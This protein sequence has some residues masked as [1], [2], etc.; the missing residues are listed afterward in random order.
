MTG[1]TFCLVQR[2]T[3]VMAIFCPVQLSFSCYRSTPTKYLICEP[4]G[5]LVLTVGVVRGFV[6]ALLSCYCREV[7]RTKGFSEV[8]I[9]GSKL[10]KCGTLWL[11]MQLSLNSTFQPTGLLQKLSC[12]T[13]KRLRSLPTKTHLKSVT[14]LFCFNRAYYLETRTQEHSKGTHILLVTHGDA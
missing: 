5:V 9:I 6:G 10:K 4:M 1:P 8:L 12:G 7:M 13:R 3:S 14:M 11:H 2:R